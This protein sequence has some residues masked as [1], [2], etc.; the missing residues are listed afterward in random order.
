MKNGCLPL[1]E[2]PIHTGRPVRVIVIGA[3]FGGIGAGVYL[4]QHIKDLDLQIYERGTDI[5]GVWH[6]NRYMGA[7][8]DIPAHT[9]QYTFAN[10]S[11]WSEFYAGSKEIHGYL[12]SVADHYKLWPFI[13]VQHKVLEA[14][15]LENEGKWVVKIRGPTG[16]EFEDKCDFLVT[17]T[18]FLSE[19]GWPKIPGRENF[20]GILHHTGHWDAEKEEAEG[21]DWS[22]KR[23]GV[24]G[25]G[26]SAI[27]VVPVMQKKCKELVNFART[28][29]W[30]TPTFG[31]GTLKKLGVD[32][33][34]NSNHRFTDEEKKHFSNED[35][36]REFR[37]MIERDLAG[38]H[39]VTHRDNPLQNAVRKASEVGMRH[40]LASRPDIEEALVPDIPIA[41]RRVTPGPGYLESLMQDNVKLVTDGV[42]S[43]T[44]HGVKTTSGEEF[45]FDAIIC[46]TGFDTANVPSFPIYGKD[47][48]N[49]QDIYAEANEVKTYL[50][51]TA[52]KMPNFFTILGPQTGVSSGVG[53][54]SMEQQLA[55]IAK[56]VSKCQRDGYKSMVVKQEPVDSFMKYT[57]AY[58]ERTV[59]TVDCNSWFK[60]PK[61]KTPRGGNRIRVLWPGSSGHLVLALKEPRWED[62]DY[63]I[64]PEYKDT[65]GWLGNGNIP[66][67]LDPVFYYEELRAGYKV[68]LWKY[69]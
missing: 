42:A 58:F 16:Q 36:Y 21:M 69:M 4:P 68:G 47:G 11:K 54:I 63:T 66:A 37:L 13:K 20:K 3:G 5:G 43:F 31:D 51:I 55:Y 38:V 32:T 56:A 28:K 41:C 12:K 17:A 26:S 25:S 18:G 67:D 22:D 33:E 15:W 48:I 49:L 1:V 7:A 6:Y 62:Y 23:V 46:A 8:C 60:D 44:E 10:N 52:P 61:G 53:L 29:T 14:H 24:I 9:Y 27:Q 57:D 30:I 45:E 64:L 34:K 59:F 35:N 65:M 19:P 39:Y 40:R 2:K 50:A